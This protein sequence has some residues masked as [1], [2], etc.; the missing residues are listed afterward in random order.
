MASEGTLV[1][2]SQATPLAVIRRIDPVQVDVT[3][4]AAEIIRW[5]RQGISEEIQN[6]SNAAVI[7]HLADG[8]EYEQ[9]GS[10]MGAEPHVDETTGVVTLRMEFGNPDG[11]LL[12]GMY[13]LAEIPQARLENAVLAPQDGVTRDRRGRP[14]GY[15]VNADNVV[16]ERSLD[17]IQDLGN[18]WVIRDGLSAG[19]RLVV[20][21]FQY[22]APGATVT[23]EERQETA[24]ADSAAAAAPEGGAQPTDAP[25]EGTDASDMPA[26]GADAPDATAAGDAPSD[27]ADEPASAEGQPAE[28][29]ETPAGN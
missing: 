19:D 10:L 5:Q 27:A 29:G 4:S 11:L 18:R 25:A 13:V 6:D 8:S 12:P 16:E 7:L 14:V 24:P 26:Q 21:G 23:P 22:I 15:I 9:A 2:A 20:A 3:Q 17:I 28:A 1:T